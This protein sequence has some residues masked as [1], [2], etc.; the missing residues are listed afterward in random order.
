M[1]DRRHCR[2]ER[3]AALA[4]P[5]LNLF[6]K[7]YISVILFSRH[8]LL[9]VD[10]CG[11]DHD[12]RSQVVVVAHG[13]QIRLHFRWFP[14]PHLLHHALVLHHHFRG[15]RFDRHAT[16]EAECLNR[17]QQ[18]RH[19]RTLQRDHELLTLHGVQQGVRPLVF[20]GLDEAVIVVEHHQRARQGGEL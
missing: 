2:D 7:S 11:V 10:Q 17:L 6:H 19:L 16:V 15:F 3:F 4:P 20:L 5:T 14:L 9:V 13:Q 8:Q 1:T 12:K 18:R